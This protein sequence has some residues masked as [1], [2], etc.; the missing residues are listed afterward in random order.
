MKLRLAKKILKA[1]QQNENAPY[2]AEQLK[3]AEN[4]MNRYTK[5]AKA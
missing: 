3:K 4:R 5:N 1:S 2:H